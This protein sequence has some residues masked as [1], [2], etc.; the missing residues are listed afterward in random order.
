M[1]RLLKCAIATILLGLIVPPANSAPT[2]PS[3]LKSAIVDLG[4]EDP[5]LRRQAQE[6]IRAAGRNARPALLDAANSGDP[7]VAH[8]ARELLLGIPWFEPTDPPAV[9]RQLEGYGSKD[10]LS[11][12]E[13][14]AE[15]VNRFGT[16]AAPVLLRLLTEDPS[17]AVR[18]QIVAAIQADR[19]LIPPDKLAALGDA[20][21]DNTP[22]LAAR[23]AALAHQ[24]HDDPDAVLPLYRRIVAL[25]SKNPTRD[26][27]AIQPIFDHLIGNNVVNRRFDAAA[28]LY[29]IAIFRAQVTSP[30]DV[31]LPVLRLFAVHAAFGPL[32]RFADDVRDHLPQLDPPL[33]MHAM[34]QVARGS[35][36]WIAAMPLDDVARSMVRSTNQ[37]IRLADLLNIVGWQDA[38]EEQLRY[39]LADKPPL[40]Q[41][42]DIHLRLAHLRGQAGDDLAAAAH[43][44]AV[45]QLLDAF[46]G[47][48]VRGDTRDAFSWLGEQIQ[49]R[50]L[51][52]AR[53]RG[54]LAAV[55]KHV[56]QLLRAQTTDPD[57]L[58][59]LLPALRD[60]DRAAEGDRLAENA[61][62]Q[63]K[64]LLDADPEDPHI[65]NNMAWLLA[66]TNQ[67]LDEALKFANWATTAS[68]YNSAFIDTLAEVHYRRGNP[69]QSVQ[70]E[71]KA[72]LL[73]PG[74]RF[75]TSQLNKFRA[76]ESAD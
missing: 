13:I 39:L 62:R 67:R 70:L 38:A 2:E 57:I 41:Q 36:N 75:M 55:E 29:R 71:Q 10:A 69:E 28:D 54:D 65:L 64:P 7:A 51:R 61:Y 20:D 43:L 60:L 30:H 21:T 11:R 31:S 52:D 23:A 4:S 40:P 22:I 66:R 18:W 17:D 74:D 72:L 26:H 50:Q 25:E 8:A 49:W 15:L 56:E 32:P 1:S 47:M 73:N 48:V 42:I 19:N 34:A 33:R 58:A 12:R 16:D 44:Q 5:V 9:R 35:G 76:A 3:D 24:S 37:P 45:L 6:R 46:E 59:D 63:V 14:V 53:S 27:G 68:P